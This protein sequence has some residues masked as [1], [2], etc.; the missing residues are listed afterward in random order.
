[1]E[2]SPHILI[3]DDSADIREP[4][5]KY[6]AKSGMR[7]ST[8]NGGVEMRRLLKT[9]AIDL[10]V[11]DIMMPGEDGLSLC[12]FVRETTDLPVILLTAMAEDTDRVVGLEIGADD[13]VTKPF[14]PRELLARV[15]AVLR[16]SRA[17]PRQTEQ[18]KNAEIRFDRWT[19]DTARREIVGEDGVAIPLSTTEYRLLTVFVR[20][21]HMVLSRDQLLDLTSGRSLEPFERS[22]DNQISRLRKKIEADPKAPTI[23]KTVW[24]GGYV[25]ACDV[26]ER[27]K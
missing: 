20:R 1:M 25:L 3:V 24:G 27:P 10:V 5:A 12:R 16:R 4:L 22:I 19:L 26:E 2:T 11:L 14:N 21:P 8:A 13:Y 6:L 23:V 18:P 7:T 9:N 15:K 17:L